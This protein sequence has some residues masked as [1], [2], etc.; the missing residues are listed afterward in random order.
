MSTPTLTLICPACQT[1]FPAEAGLTDPAARAALASALRLWPQP[2]RGAVLR[3]LGLHR[4]REK[5]LRMDRLARLLES[6][7]TLI[8]SGE[9]TRH[10]ETRPAP[11]TAWG[12][13]LTEVL[14]AAE[15]GTLDLPLA[16]HGLLCQIVWDTAG[17]AQVRAAAAVRPLHPSHRPA[18]APEAASVTPPAVSATWT[19]DH[20]AAGMTQAGALLGALKGRLNHPEPTPE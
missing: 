15:A 16:G 19:P 14:R 6:L 11:V 17:R 7:V 2:L 9:V 5:A 1:P 18:P 20:R 13:G 12:E 4:P 3:Y 8:E 10:R